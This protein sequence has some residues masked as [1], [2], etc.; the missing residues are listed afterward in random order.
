MSQFKNAQI[1]WTS[2]VCI[3]HLIICFKELKLLRPLSTSDEVRKRE[4]RMDDYVVEVAE[5]CKNNQLRCGFC[6]K[7]LKYN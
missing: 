2:F 1:S 4:A 6:L 7:Y 3:C 5:K